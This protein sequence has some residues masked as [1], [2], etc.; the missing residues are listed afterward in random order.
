MSAPRAEPLRRRGSRTRVRVITLASA[1]LAV[2]GGSQPALAQLL[3]VTN[4]R[5]HPISSAVIERGTVVIRDGR[6]VAVGASVAVPQGARVIDAAG[7]VVTP[8]LMDSFTTLGLTE[9]GLEQGTVDAPTSEDHITAA[10][11]VADGLNPL[12][13]LLPVTRVEGITRAVV[14]PQSGASL[15]AGQGVVIDLGAERVDEM[16]H[17]NPVAMFAVFGEAGAALAGGSRAAAALVLR[18]ALQDARDFAENRRAW[19]ESRRREYALGRLDLQALVPVVRGE[20]PLVVQASRASDLLTAIRLAREFDIQLILAGATEAWMVASEIAAAGVPVVINPMQNIPGFESLGVTL[21]NAA[22][23]HAAG[24]TVAF[25]SFDAHN[26]RNL[27]Q[28]AGNAVSYGMPHD[29][30]LRAVTLT[31]AR[32][33]GVADRY[34]SIEAGMDADLVIWSG[35][36]F[37]LTTTAERVFIAGR[38]MPPDTRQRSLLEKYRQIR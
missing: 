10:F 13:T 23:L 33:W 14:A 37:E 9:I 19:E 38:E 31:P 32:M 12:S 17:R 26:V 16:V 35:D 36:P 5:I 27:K 30:A 22:R 3:A 25:A 28:L 15:I 20:L 2:S 34:G 7:K 4:A 11:N 18:E 21:E 8:G 1:V 6:I 29:A 24:V